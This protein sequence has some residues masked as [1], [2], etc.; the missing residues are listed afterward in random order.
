VPP[1]VVVVVGAVVVVVG[2]EDV[3]VTL[4]PKSS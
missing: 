1:D 2:D 3:H 4:A